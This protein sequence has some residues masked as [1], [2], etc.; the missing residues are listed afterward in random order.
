MEHV[1]AF[2]RELYRNN[3]RAWFA[4]HKEEYLRVKATVERFAAELIDGIAAFDDS[5]RG[6]GVN[7][8]TY[9]IYRD[10][11]FSPDKRP[12]KQHIGIFICPGGKK[13]GR[14]GYY[15]HIEPR[16][17]DSETDSATGGH[18]LVTGLYRPEPRVLHSVREEMLYNGAQLEENIARATR[19]GFTLSREN[20]LK[21]QPLGF[22]TD[23]PYASYLRLRD[24]LLERPLSDADLTAPDL[25]ARTLA[26]FASTAGFCRQLNRAVEYALEEE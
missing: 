17:S 11:R 19:E 6:L 3:D 20:Q 5:V 23:T 24:V 12:Y 26:A 10:T 16:H 4:A 21:R 8:C 15:F 13:S 9:R 25:T 2:L 14:S 22:P 7:D 18:F 1:I